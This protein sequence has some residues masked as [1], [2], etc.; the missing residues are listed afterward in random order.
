MGTNTLYFPPPE[1]APTHT[2]NIWAWVMYFLSPYIKTV[3]I[4]ACYRP[5]RCTCL[6]MTPIVIGFIIEALE[7][8]QVTQNPDTYFYILA[9]FWVLFTA[10][11]INNVFAPEIRVFEKASRILT[12]YGIQHLNSLS[13]EWHASQG[14]GKK[15]QRIMHARHCFI[16]LARFLR[17]DVSA[18]VGDIIAISISFAMMDIPLQF[19][20]YFIGLILCYL[21]STWYFSR[22]F[23]Q[24]F[25]AVNLKMEKLMSGVYEFVSAI[26]T[27]KSFNLAP[28]VK[29]RAAQL[30]EEALNTS[31]K[32]HSANLTRW[33]M[34]NLT[35]AFWL[36]IFAFTGFDA[37]I[38]GEMTAGAF[39][40]IFFLA[41]RIWFSCENVGVVFDKLY[42][43]VSG[44]KLYVETV[45]TPPE[46]MDKTPAAAMPSNWK[47]IQ[48]SSTS[49][50]YTDSKN[51]GIHNIS[52][53]VKKGEKI[54]LVGASGAGKSTLVNLL[55]KQ[56]L[57]TAGTIAVDSTDLAYIPTQKW[58]EHLAYVPQDIE[59]FNLSLRDNICLDKSNV[60]DQDIQSAL[61]LAALNEFVSSLPEGLSTKIGERGVKLSGGQRQ[62]LGIARALLRNADILILDEATSALDSVSE[63]KIKHAIDNSLSGRTAFIVAHRLSTIK[64]VDRI[65]VLDHG[66][67]IEQGSFDD[68]IKQ[69]GNFAKMW[70]LQSRL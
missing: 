56:A 45:C 27:V 30:E 6:S 68:L 22:N 70:A 43:Y 52:L 42:E 23:P 1:K 26:K 39:A 57:P 53:T 10:M 65:I 48:L 17:W 60:T 38:K 14:S 2:H 28:H 7:T 35:M 37:V 3:A 25:G 58:L 31:M 49:Y 46:V 64:H 4:Y 36:G 54:A 40:A 20:L 33:T 21:G 24:L 34:A 66:H 69:D 61:K 5:I 11:L 59:L 18:L 15:M 13:T 8:G 12:I 19:A 44:L 55:L 47:T 51:Q 29:N 41:Y 50:E 9:G 16:E 63:N 32:A 62:R 67:I